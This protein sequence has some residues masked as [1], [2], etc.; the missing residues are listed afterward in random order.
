MSNP[1]ALSPSQQEIV[2][3]RGGDLQIIACAGSGK[4][5]AISRQV[6]SLIVE[7]VAP[8]SII[9]F[10]FTEKAGAELKER[11]YQ[12]VEECSGSD[13]LDTLGPMFVGTIHGWCFHALQERVPR[14]GDYEVIDEHRHAALLN[15]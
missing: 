15:R 5:E 11:I 2:S 9:A 4:T 13:I 7:D 12:R 3:Q 14:Y 8:A 1:I 10:T 6:A